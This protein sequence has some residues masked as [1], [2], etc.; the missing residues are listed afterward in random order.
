[1]TD[2]K[3]KAWESAPV[4]RGEMMELILPLVLSSAAITKSVSALGLSLVDSEDPE[5]KIAAIKSLHLSDDAKK[6]LRELQSLLK[7]IVAEPGEGNGSS[8]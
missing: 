6:H 2:E 5:L 3:E 1:M 8:S 7:E 4:T